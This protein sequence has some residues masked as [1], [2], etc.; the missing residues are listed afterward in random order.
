MYATPRSRLRRLVLAA[1]L[2]A[3]AIGIFAAGH[4][5]A[6]FFGDVAVI[7]A[8]TGQETSVDG[9]PRVCGFWLEFDFDRTVDVV[10]WEIKEWS[11]SPLDGATV[12]QGNGG[13]TDA[14]GKLRQPDS[15]SLTLPD[16]HYSIVWDDEAG[17]DES[18]GLQS[19][20]VDCDESTGTQP[21]PTGTDLGVGGIVGGPA[22]TLPPTDTEPA[23]PMANETSLIAL[24]IALLALM[25]LALTTSHQ[26]LIARTTRRSR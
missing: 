20:V 21:T 4:A 19:F 22:A 1:V 14:D 5:S 10:T 8:D 24:A 25:T 13:P 3:L 26:R 23:E 9:E 15:G 2:G 18:F 7:D 17:V 12:L 16:G 11:A 6:G